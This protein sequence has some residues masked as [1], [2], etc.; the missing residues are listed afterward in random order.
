MWTIVIIIL[1]SSTLTVRAFISSCE[2]MK[3]MTTEEQLCSLV[4]SKEEVN[5]TTGNESLQSSDRCL[6]MWD[7]ITC[8]LS[9][10]IGQTV[11]VPCPKAFQ[12]VTGKTGFIYR[13]CTKD[14]W[15]EKY[16]RPYIACGLNVEEINAPIVAW[17]RRVSY[18]R[19]LE[20]VYTIG[21]SASL[22]ALTI[23]LGILGS[24]RRLRCTRNCIH[25]Q[26][27]ASFILRAL[28]NFIRDPVLSEDTDDA[29]YCE[30]HMG[31]CKIIMIFINFCIMA[32]Y[33]W[34]LVEGLYLHTLLV[35]SFFSER[36]FFW[37][38]V[39]LGWGKYQ[40]TPVGEP[41]QN[42]AQYYPP[43]TPF[44]SLLCFPCL[45]ALFFA[46]PHFVCLSLPV[47]L[48]LWHHNFKAHGFTHIILGAVATIPST[49]NMLL[50]PESFGGSHVL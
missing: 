6:G 28:A 3:I 37:W 35:M 16:P 46:S 25:M 31:R 21:T 27:F 22:V 38:F 13:N 19:K 5:A 39:V 42:A 17:Q 36:K 48:H 18:L 12:M 4:L 2:I 33:S 14:G 30:L 7:N 41:Q 1:S 9:S 50:F 24:F 15:S 10:S 49:L 47:L 11:S 29:V 34:L 40:L 26:L 8:W 45:P 20:I 23:A 44:Q 32:N 43:L